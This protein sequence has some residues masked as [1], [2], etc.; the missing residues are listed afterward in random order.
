MGQEI[1]GM[2]ATTSEVKGVS[3]TNVD[4]VLPQPAED[5]AIIG[6]LSKI[7]DSIKNHVQ[8]YYYSGPISHEMVDEARLV[9]LSQ[10]TGI[11]TS[12]LLK[13]LFNPT[14][15]LPTIR[16]FLGYSILSRCQ[17][18]TDGQPSFLPNEV[19]GLAAYQS[20]ANNA[21][22]CKS[23][24]LLCLV[25]TNDPNQAQ[26]ALFSKW[27]TI[28]GV[29]LQQ[30]YGQQPSDNDVQNGNIAQ[31]LAVAESVLHPFI[32]P[33]IDMNARQ[34]NLEGIMKRAAQFAFLLFSQPGSFSFDFRGGGQPDS[35][36]V[37]PAFLQTV[38]DEAE[39]LSPP[40]VLGETEVVSG[41]GM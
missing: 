13:F 7:R 16:L 32:N 30:Q 20:S 18:R 33:D 2:V 27:K 12:A 36:L 34:R 37:F 15:R 9:D 41:L 4:R 22:S 14:T 28:S 1:Y 25:R 29:L 23:G 3:A 38:S 26:S 11:P 40:R 21:N 10:A 6:G 31:I 24:L 35:L 17:G 8:N 19:S 39:I 5:D